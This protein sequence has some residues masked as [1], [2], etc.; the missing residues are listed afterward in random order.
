MI[1]AFAPAAR[2]STD[3]QWSWRRPARRRVQLT[4]QTISPTAAARTPADC[5]HAVE[6]AMNPLHGEVPAVAAVEATATTTAAVAANS[7]ALMKATSLQGEPEP[8]TTERRGRIRVS[9]TRIGRRST[10]AVPAFMPPG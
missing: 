4:R 7:V 6:G 8:R 9:G 2:P 5:A 10:V 3:D 1:P